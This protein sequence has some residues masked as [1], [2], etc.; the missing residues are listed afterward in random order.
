MSRCLKGYLIIKYSGFMSTMSGTSESE[1]AD[2]VKI[3]RLRDSDAMAASPPAKDERLDSST[4][5]V[6]MHVCG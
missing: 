5:G 3:E 4:E 6:Y 1:Q 2:A